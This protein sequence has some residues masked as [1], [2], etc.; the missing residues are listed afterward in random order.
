MKRKIGLVV[1][2]GIVA[3]VAFAL[4]NGTY[5]ATEPG[6]DER[7]YVASIKIVVK[8]GS[9]SKVEYDESKGNSSKWK[10]KNYN[11]TM[12]K[13]AGTAW[14]DAVKALES[15]LVKKNNAASVDA[16]SGATELSARFKTLAAKALGM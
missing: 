9:I 7:G 10:D 12:K 13:I 14:I 5:T 11:A 6:P 15:S 3:S 2:F 4:N 16:V 1:L 8:G